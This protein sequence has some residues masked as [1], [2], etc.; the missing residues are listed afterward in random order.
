MKLEK[1][2]SMSCVMENIHNVQKFFNSEEFQE[3][4][5]EYVEEKIIL[6]RDTTTYRIKEVEKFAE[7][8]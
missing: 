5:W 2:K 1:I 8:L 7:E 6:F 4:N 3:R